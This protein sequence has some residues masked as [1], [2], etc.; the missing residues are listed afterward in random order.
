VL[1][2]DEVDTGVSGEV[3]LA[4][5][6]RLFDLGKTHQVLCV[7]HL[8][9]VASFAKTHFEV[10]KDVAKGRTFTKVAALEGERRLETL[11]RM[12]G[13]REATATSRRHAQELLE[14][15]Q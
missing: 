7:T 6:R 13:G 15:C 14:A 12:L 2:F 5:G 11:A 1:V 4:V 8:P 9:Q 10:S 3:G